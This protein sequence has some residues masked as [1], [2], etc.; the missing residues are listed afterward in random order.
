LAQKNEVPKILNYVV[1]GGQAEH[2]Y[3]RVG[4]FDRCGPELTDEQQVDGHGQ[5]GVE[6]VGVA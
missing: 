2:C 4:L 1:R 6:R 5:N 3:V